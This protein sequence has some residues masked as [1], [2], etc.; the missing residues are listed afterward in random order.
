MQGVDEKKEIRRVVDTG[1]VEF[2]YNKACQG[3]T[4]GKGHLVIMSKNIPDTNA[5]QLRHYAGIA[6]IPLYTFDGTGLEL[7]K[8][9]GKPFL[10]S[11]MLVQD[12]GKSKV[13]ELTK[14]KGEKPSRARSMTTR[15]KR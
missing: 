10:V 12:E 3:L 8:V 9:C 4:M 6:G 7:G 14:E 11:A 15:T 2:G 1:K 5:E 13:L